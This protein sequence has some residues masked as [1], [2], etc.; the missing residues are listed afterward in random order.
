MALDQLAFAPL[1]VGSMMML[2]SLADG[3]PFDAARRS[4]AQ[5]LPS[6]VKANWAL[7][8]PAQFVNFRYVPPNLQVG[9]SNVVAL[10]WN[11]YF[12]YATGG[13]G[14]GHAAADGGNGKKKGGKK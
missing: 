14:G 3:T 12:S 8:V 9:F 7:W 11:V 10:L 2:L 4:V 6:A 5:G 1:F 13:G